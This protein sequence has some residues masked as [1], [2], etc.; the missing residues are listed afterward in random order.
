MKHED[1]TLKNIWEWA[2]KREKICFV[3]DGILMCLTSTNGR[4]SH[5]V[6]VPEPL[7]M[8][9][10]KLAHDMS[11]HFG[12][13]ATRAF[14]NPNFTWP[15]LHKDIQ[16][17]IKSCDKCQRYAKSSPPKAPLIPADIIVERFDKIAVDI[18]GPIQKS[19]RG[20]R[21]I[22]TAMDLASSFVFARP[23]KGFT[24]D[25]TAENLLAI[26]SFTGPP[27][28]IL[29]DQGSNFLSK[30]LSQL[31]DKFAIQRIKTSPYRPQSNGQLERVHS[32]L[33][34]VLRKI[35]ADK[36]DWPLVLDLVLYFLRNLPHSRHGHTPYELIF[37][38]PTPH[39]LATLKS[40]WVHQENESLNASVFLESLHHNINTTIQTL[41]ERLRDDTAKRELL[42]I[43]ANFV[44]SR[45]VILCGGVSQV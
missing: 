36:H 7:R 41:K 33:K 18:V 4:Y 24:S 37:M 31:Y 44:N 29:S 8:K 19:K 10:L 38:K 43:T 22:L 11:G 12:T 23:M 28:A 6:V 13:G 9:V 5:S 25:E 3:V 17:Y 1:E 16:R 2:R 39:I 21:F 30:V 14:V 42:L 45:R 35:I 26:I 34:T 20:Y 15:G 40:Y 32:T 27:S